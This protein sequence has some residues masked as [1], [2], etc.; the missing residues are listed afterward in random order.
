MHPGGQ[1]LRRKAEVLQ[2]HKDNIEAELGRLR[3]ACSRRGEN[4]EIVKLKLQ[5]RCRP[6]AADRACPHIMAQHGAWHLL[7]VFF[8]F[9]VRCK[10]GS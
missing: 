5:A 7:T 8:F 10:L 9:A 1:G 4:N 6:A 3:A 2:F